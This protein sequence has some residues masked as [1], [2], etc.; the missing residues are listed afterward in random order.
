MQ[1]FVSAASGHGGAGRAH[2]RLSRRQNAQ[3]IG[4]FWVDLT[5]GTLYILLPLVDRLGARARQRRASCRRSRRTRTV[6]LVEPVEYDTP[7][8]DAAG[9]PL[10]DEKGDAGH[11]EGDQKEQVIAVG[12]AASQVAIKQLGTNGGGFFNVNSRAS[13]REPD[14]AL[15]FPRAARRSC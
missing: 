9:Q 6:P 7:K 3:T 15:E 13:A 4:N 10:K 8:L 14:A 2:P 1:N 5:R 11:R 12:P